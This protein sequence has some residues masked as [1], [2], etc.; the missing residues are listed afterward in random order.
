[1]KREFWR[2]CLSSEHRFPPCLH[3]ELPTTCYNH[4]I[5]TYK[6]QYSWR[7]WTFRRYG[8]AIVCSV[9]YTGVPHP[10]WASG[11]TFVGHCVRQPVAQRKGRQCWYAG[12]SHR[13]FKYRWKRNQGFEI[14]K[15]SAP[16]K[17]NPSSGVSDT[18]NIARKN[19]FRRC[20]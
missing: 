18:E 19:P 10:F 14:W 20:V 5:V 3:A 13:E 17:C 4:S 8:V 11:C 7:V 16:K 6:C 12:C 2:F 1:M 9:C 15:L